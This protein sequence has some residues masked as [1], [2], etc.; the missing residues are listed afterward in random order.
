MEGTNKSTDAGV[1][2]EVMERL[3]E[4]KVITVEADGIK[5]QVLITP[6]KSGIEAQ[7]V[8]EFVEPYR[9]NPERR[10]GMA[11]LET[12]DSLIAHV[13]RFKDANSVLYCSLAVKAHPSMT[14]VLDYHEPTGG[15][16]RFGKHKAHY[17][18]PLSDEWE[19]WSG[20]NNA[21]LSQEV[22]AQFLDQH[23]L[24]GIDP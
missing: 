13:N 4:P 22:F 9:Q 8:R 14:A 20:K 5:A 3:Y 2:A 7:G 11:V 12:L 15:K 17:T 21:P 1:V 19:A 18:F 16:P 24:D 23:I 10:Q 6:G